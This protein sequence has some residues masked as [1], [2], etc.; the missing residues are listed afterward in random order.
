MSIA[1]VLWWCYIHEINMLLKNICM[2]VYMCLGGIFRST[3]AL[4]IKITEVYGAVKEVL[5]DQKE[6][7]MS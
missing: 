5:V 2:L 1:P 3:K 6:V 7:F 4:F